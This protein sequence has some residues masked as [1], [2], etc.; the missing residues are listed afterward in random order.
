[1][2]IDSDL[3]LA[4]Q[5]FYGATLRITLSGGG[6]DGVALEPGSALPGHFDFGTLAPHTHYSI[7]IVAADAKLVGAISFETGEG[8]SSSAVGALRVQSVSESQWSSSSFA[9]ENC[10]NILFA[11][12]CYDTGVPPIQTFDVDAGSSSIDPRTLWMTETIHD[13][14]SYFQRLPVACGKP[15]HFKF[16]SGGADEHVYNVGTNGAIRES[17]LLV[18]GLV[19]PQPSPAPPPEVAAPQPNIESS[20]VSCDLAPSADA[21]APGALLM[22]SALCAV[23][24]GRRASGRQRRR[25][26]RYVPQG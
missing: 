26:L 8:Q 13:G 16:F 3:L 22:A 19:P 20:E 1:V 4:T 5:G 9:S 6:A 10:D 18:G 11:D 21:R 14:E 25:A 2:P 12:S 7:S 15:V 17:D 23:V 24:L